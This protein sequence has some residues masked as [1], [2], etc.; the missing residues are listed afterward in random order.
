MESGINTFF[1]KI[2]GNTSQLHDKITRVKNS[3]LQ[4]MHGIENLRSFDANIIIE[5]VINKYNYTYITE[6]ADMFAK[7][8]AKQIILKVISLPYHPKK[9]LYLKL[10]KYTPLY[11]EI[12]PHVKNVLSSFPEGFISVQK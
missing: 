4:T 9:N 7:M 5:L 3:F 10:R 8:G 6:I 11:S 12:A 2:Y 1:I